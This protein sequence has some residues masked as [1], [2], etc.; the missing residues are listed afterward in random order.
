MS[1]FGF[2]SFPSYETI[3][4]FTELDTINLSDASFANHQKHARG[5]SLIREYMERDFPIPSKGADYVYMSQVLQA[6]G[7]TKGIYAHRRAKPYN[8]GTLYWQL[9]DCWP[10]VSWSSIDGLGNWKA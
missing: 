6:Y 10:A 3:K 7:M 8:M 4:Y 1:E 2:Q 9:N 5:F